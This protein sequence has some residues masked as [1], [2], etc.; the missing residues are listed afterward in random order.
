MP[1]RGPARAA[2]ARRG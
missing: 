1:N 2:A